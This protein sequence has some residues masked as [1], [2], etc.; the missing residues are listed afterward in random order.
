M[1]SVRRL[2]RYLLTTAERSAHEASMRQC[3]RCEAPVSEFRDA[4][5]LELER[6][7]GHLV[8]PVSIEDN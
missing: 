7:T 3:L 8:T 2:E 6:A 1:E 4:R 5:P